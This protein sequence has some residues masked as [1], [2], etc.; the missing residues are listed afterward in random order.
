MAKTATKAPPT[1]AQWLKR[2]DA[3]VFKQ[4]PSVGS[5]LRDAEV[6]DFARGFGVPEPVLAEAFWRNEYHLVGVY[7]PLGPDLRLRARFVGAN[8][9]WDDRPERFYDLT[10]AGADQAARDIADLL[11]VGPSRLMNA[12]EN[13]RDAAHYVREMQRYDGVVAENGSL[14]NGLN[15]AELLDMYRRAFKNA[16]AS[17]QN[18]ANQLLE[19]AQRADYLARF[20]KSPLLDAINGLRNHDV[21]NIMASMSIGTRIDMGGGGGSGTFVTF[22]SSYLNALGPTLPLDL[23][24]RVPSEPTAEALA[25]LTAIVNDVARF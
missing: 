11:R 9:R 25:Q 7:G 8:T 10:D 19:T 14:F 3:A 12:R 16:I 4:A 24:W 17:L 18:A 21:H 23:H 6:R 15:S 5:A 1:K 22:N 20:A 2:V 13:M